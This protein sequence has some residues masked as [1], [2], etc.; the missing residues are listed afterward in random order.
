MLLTAVNTPHA[1]VCFLSHSS[2][3]LSR[4]VTSS[5]HAMSELSSAKERLPST[6]AMSLSPNVGL[7]KTRQLSAMTPCLVDAHLA[8]TECTHSL[9]QFRL[10]ATLSLSGM[11]S[12]QTLSK[13]NSLRTAGLKSCQPAGHMWNV[14]HVSIYEKINAALLYPSFVWTF[15]EN[16]LF[17]TWILS[18]TFL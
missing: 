14:R 8:S 16:L 1:K 5:D 18:C 12:V 11:I 4:A 9:L 2:S 7:D 17:S 10:P 13:F 3:L 6:T 15:D